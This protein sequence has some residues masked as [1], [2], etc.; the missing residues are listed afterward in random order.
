METPDTSTRRSA[1]R[2]TRLGR[3]ASEDRFDLSAP[4]SRQALSSSLG[5]LTPHSA[6]SSNR[7]RQSQLIRAELP[8]NGYPQPSGSSKNARQWHFIR[9]ERSSNGSSGSHRA[10]EGSS[11]PSRF[12]LFVILLR[13]ATPALR[14][15]VIGS[16]RPLELCDVTFTTLRTQVRPAIE[17]ASGKEGLRPQF[18]LVDDLL[19][20]AT[21]IRT[22]QVRLLGHPEFRKRP[23]PLRGS[24]GRWQW[25]S[26]RP[27]ALLSFVARFAPRR[28]ISGAVTLTFVPLCSLY[29]DS[30][31][32]SRPQPLGGVGDDTHCEDKREDFGLFV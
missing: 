25:R 32:S 23:W 13:L 22:L 4:P 7:A 1:L 17:L 15:G 11:L 24:R 18:W 21:G 27:L 19:Y 6:R 20:D 29:S 26:L 31:L 28:C 12:F 10:L 3:H 8:S 30:P 14:L 9:A 5:G 16:L 2:A